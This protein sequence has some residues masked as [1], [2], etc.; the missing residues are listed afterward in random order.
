M[1]HGLLSIFVQRILQLVIL[2]LCSFFHLMD[3]SYLSFDELFPLSLI[4]LVV[5]LAVVETQYS[6]MG[7]SQFQS[8]SINLLLKFIDTIVERSP[9]MFLSHMFVRILFDQANDPCFH[10][11]VI[12]QHLLRLQ[13]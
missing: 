2:E 10:Q 6:V 9:L 7:V 8:L 1:F 5:L 12:S 3:I 4:L 11:E 13:I